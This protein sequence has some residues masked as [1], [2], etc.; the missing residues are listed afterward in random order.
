MAK[1]PDDFLT[2]NRKKSVAGAD[3]EGRSPEQSKVER[4]KR[5][6]DSVPS[7]K[8]V[9]DLFQNKRRKK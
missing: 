4:S 2:E 8:P 6:R 9:Y 5:D 7:G 1:A 3:A